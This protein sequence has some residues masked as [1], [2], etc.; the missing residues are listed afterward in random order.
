MLKIPTR[1]KAIEYLDWAEKQ[2]PGLWVKHCQH[3]AKAAETIASH[4]INMDG[5][6]AFVLGLLHD[7]GRYRGVTSIKHIYDGYKLMLKDGFPTVAQICLTHSFPVQDFNFYA[8]GENDCSDEET[9]ELISALKKAEYSD[10]DRLIQLCDSIATIDGVCL[11]EKRLMDVAMRYGV[12]SY[13]QQYWQ[14]MFN[15]R[16]DFSRRL[17]KS[18]YSLFSEVAEI[19]LR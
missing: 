5:E 8:G 6:R 17:G 14:Q 19:T 11:M 10:Y 12:K 7:I 13:S 18:I 1:K 2:N 3:V 15:I 9:Q 16:D 4:C